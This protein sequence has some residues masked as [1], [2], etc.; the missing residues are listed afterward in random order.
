[1]KSLYVFGLLP[2]FVGGTNHK[3]IDIDPKVLMVEFYMFSKIL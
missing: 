2:P 3:T 1:L